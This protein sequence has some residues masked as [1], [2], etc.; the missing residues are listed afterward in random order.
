MPIVET[1]DRRVLL[2]LGYKDLK[3][4]IDRQ[5]L[6]A[7][8]RKNELRRLGTSFDGLKGSTLVFRTYSS[9]YGLPKEDGGNSKIWTQEVQLLDLAEALRMRDMR[10]RD[11]VRLAFD[12][13][14][15]V[16]CDCP[17]FVYWGFGYIVS[18]LGAGKPGETYDPEWPMLINQAPGT[19]PTQPRRRRNVHQR[20]TV[21]KH[22]Y[23]VF[24]HVGFFQMDVVSELKRQGI[25]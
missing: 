5:Y 15:A 19:Y 6:D 1:T 11:R 14:V 25:E 3:T 9:K 12:G 16:K 23:L 7:E 8:R 21:C 17:A 18:Q 4:G 22:L 20:G 24:E 13:D 10:L 2:E